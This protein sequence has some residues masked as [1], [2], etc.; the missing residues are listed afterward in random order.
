MALK[1]RLLALNDYT[2]NLFH[3]TNGHITFI[4][5]IITFILSRDLYV[6]VRHFI[7]VFLRTGL[8]IIALR[9][10]KSVKCSR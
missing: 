5:L 4:L 3:M 1:W 6:K 10:E 2:F 9:P 8:I 7:G